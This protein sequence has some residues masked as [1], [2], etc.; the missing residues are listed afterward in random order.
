[1]SEDESDRSEH[2][3]F[4]ELVRRRMFRSAG[5]YIVASWVLVQVASIVLPEF[6]APRWAMRS[7]IV[8]LIAGFPFAM[9]LAWMLDI[10]PSGIRRTQHSHYSRSREG[11]LRGSVVLVASLVSAGALWW[12]WT[13]Y[14]IPATQRPAR[15][16][17]KQ[18][19]IVAVSTPR[20]ISGTEDLAWLGEG[21]ADLIRNELAESPHIIVLS[22][23]G[24]NRIAGDADSVA[25]QVELAR[26][27][28][29]DYL[30]AGQ[31]LQTNDGI[32]L[33]LGIDDLENEIEIQGVRLV[34]DDAAKL[35][36]ASASSAMSKS[37]RQALQIPM[38]EN[39]QRFAADFATRN[40]D[41]YEAYIAGL[42][43][44]IDFNYARA[45]DAF[46]AALAIAPDYHM[47]RFRLA[48]TLEAAGQSELAFR[49]L[50]NIPDDARLTG[51][52]RLYIDGARASFI[53]E[54]DVEKTIE[55]YAEL[56]EKYPYDMEAG[57]LLA[58]AY[59]LAFDEQAAIDAFRRLAETHAYD[60]AAWMALGERLLDVGELEE[61]EAALARYV[62]EEPDDPYAHALMGNLWL[63]RGDTTRATAAYERSLRL[64][65]GFVVATLGLARS[66]YLQDRFDEAETRWRGLVEDGEAAAHHRIDAAFDLAGVLRSQRRPADAIEVL[67]AVDEPIRQEDLYTAT[68]LSTIAMLQLDAGNPDR[69]A[70][71]IDA[72][73]AESP[74]VAT[75]HLFA[76]GILE[77][78]TGR[79]EAVEATAAEIRALA[80]PPD[81]PDRTEDKA[82]SYLL[83][84]A[85]LN[86]DDL[87]TAGSLFEEALRRDGY[88]YALYALGH[89]TYLAA[90]GE[91]RA[92]ADL[93][94]RAMANRDPGDLRLD[95]EH[96]R[97]VAARLRDELLA[98]VNN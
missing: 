4:R 12:A 66:L 56:V 57:Q 97:A 7:L 3:F 53:H 55:I 69:A 70:A 30:V 22:A 9:V 10:T 78:Q 91:L 89:A 15:P 50:A 29:I 63:L 27:A 77:I 80:L 95:L 37:I 21:I 73:I 46:R 86:L 59:W 25:S 84:L 14:V 13:D 23:N 74:G 65:P 32:V 54:R 38:Q 44:V 19:P 68:M 17:I 93:A 11:I 5:A 87:E 71:L 35:V 48:E 36:S 76:R 52:E 2:G 26:D 83:G 16:A 85:A 20:M 96:E 45:E 88:E 41:A 72:A 92:A 18:N 33:T 79:L 40:M 75:R 58:E 43:Y 60:P 49:E 90:A 42:G 64:K 51:R 67:E 34:E 61:A 31:Y 82:A 47:A 28:G 62:G 24:W 8:M 94:G 6:S 1:M 81:D 98:R 39:V